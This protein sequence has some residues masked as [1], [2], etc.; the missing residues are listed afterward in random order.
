[1]IPHGVD[2]DFRPVGPPLQ[3]RAL[4]SPARPVPAHG[5]DAAAAQGSRDL[6]PR[7]VPPRAAGPRPPPRVRGQAADGSVGARDD[8]APRE[9]A[10][11]R[12]LPR[13]RAARGP[14]RTSTA[15]PR[16]SC[17][18]RGSR[19]SGCRSSR[20]WR[21]E[22]PVVAADSSSIPEVVGDGG[23]LFHA[24]R[25]QQLARSARRDPR[26]SR[27]RRAALGQRGLRRARRPSTGRRRRGG[28]SRCIGKCS[29]EHANRLR[30][31]EHGEHG[32][33]HEGTEKRP[34]H[35]RIHPLRS[36]RVRYWRTRR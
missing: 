13:I 19:A 31:R 5:R 6:D 24:G 1:M 21:A 23:V 18:R 15:T 30:E 16:R 36:R 10:R 33:T 14:A 29:R 12:A 25:P 4:R 9:R 8:R 20:R 2:D 22:L 27:R 3:P 34:C 32:G 11:S 28:T 35:T 17:C 7:A 26:R